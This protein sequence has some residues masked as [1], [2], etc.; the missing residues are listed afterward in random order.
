M[1]S[2]ITSLPVQQRDY[3]STLAPKQQA[4]SMS[5][6]S[7]GQHRTTNE[8]RTPKNKRCGLLATTTA[9]PQIPAV[10]DSLLGNPVKPSLQP[11][12]MKPVKRVAGKKSNWLEIDVE[13]DGKRCMATIREKLMSWFQASDNKLAMKLYRNH[14]ALMRERLR[15]REANNWVIH[16]C[17]DFRYVPITKISKN[18]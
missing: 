11:Q 5:C 15:Q 18:C 3:T 2:S 8:A 1:T 7:N 16:P 10:L 9:N 12:E 14:N 17:S 4:R 13:C 6:R